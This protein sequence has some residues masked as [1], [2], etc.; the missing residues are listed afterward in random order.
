[1]HL[2]DIFSHVFY[3]KFIALKFENH[4]KFKRLALALIQIL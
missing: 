2:Q 4:V 3:L 1:M